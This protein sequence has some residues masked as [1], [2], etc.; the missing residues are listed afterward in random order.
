[1]KRKNKMNL[2]LDDAINA[3]NRSLTWVEPE[4][5]NCRTCLHDSDDNLEKMPCNKCFNFMLFFHV[6]PTQWECKII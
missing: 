5:Y 4:I 6:N 2:T 1:M 3:H